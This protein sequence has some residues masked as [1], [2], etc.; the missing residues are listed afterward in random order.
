MGFALK[1]LEL[2]LPHDFGGGVVISKWCSLKGCMC[3]DTICFRIEGG[4]CTKPF[5]RIIASFSSSHSL[6]PRELV[7]S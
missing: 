1:V 3:L 5:S 6:S 4:D 2:R 7:S